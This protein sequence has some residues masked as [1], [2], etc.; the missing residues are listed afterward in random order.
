MKPGRIASI[1]W[2]RGFVMFLMVIDHASM[3]FNG[4]RIAGDS[5]GLWTPGQ[6]LPAFAFL[7]R[8]VTHLCAPTFVFLAG[9]A[10]ALMIEKRVAQGMDPK[11]VDRQILLR[12]C[13]ITVLDPTLISLGSRVL[14]FGVLFGIG[15]AMMCMVL[16]RRLPTGPLIALAIGWMAAGEWITGLVWDPAAGW[17]APSAALTLAASFPPSL[18]AVYATVPWLAVMMAGWAYGRFLTTKPTRPDGPLWIAGGVGLVLFLIVRGLNGYGNMFLPRDDATWQQWLHVSKYP[19]SL[20]F[21]AVELGLLCL[22]LAIAIRLERIVPIRPN[23]PL[24]VFGQ[25]AMFFYLAHRLAL[26][27][28]ASWF[29]LRGA[30]GLGAAYG[31]AAILLAAL[32]PACRWYRAFKA[33]HPDSWLKYF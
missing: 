25:T 15:T 23:D 26:E 29:G 2:M 12:G 18:K 1:D 28:P 31:V 24:L 19:P 32:Y 27:V 7:T 6:E 8:W 20:T 22:L 5:A 33:K 17:P 14:T 3:A 11:A 16:M 13:L 9:T 21:Y 30:G 10:L 4:D